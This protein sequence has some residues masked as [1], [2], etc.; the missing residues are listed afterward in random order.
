M[1]V[2]KASN[3]VGIATIAKIAPAIA[4]GEIAII[5]LHAS[6]MQTNYAIMHLRDR[7]LA[8]AA[9]AFCVEAREAERSYND[10]Y[11]PHSSKSERARR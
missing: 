11:S 7:T 4:T 9:L 3:A 8:P 2:V 10:P 5:P 1:H 6:W